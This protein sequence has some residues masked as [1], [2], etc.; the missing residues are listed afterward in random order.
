[1]SRRSILLIYHIAL[2]SALAVL[3]GIALL[4]TA[5]F[6]RIGPGRPSR[7]APGVSVL[8]PARNEEE[9]IERCVASLLAQEYDA[10]EVIV[11]DDQSEDRTGEILGRLK[12][13][14]AGGRLRIIAGEQ[15]PEGWTGKNYACSR[16]AGAATHEV[17][18]F[19]DADTTH[20]PG[21]ISGVVGELRSRNAALLSAVPRQL[22][23]TF[24]ERVIVPIAPFLYFCYLPNRLIPRRNHESLTAANGQVIAVEREAYRRVGGHEAIGDRIVDDLELAR[25]FKREGLKVELLRGDL[26]STCRMYRSLPEI[27]EGFSKNLYPGIG[28]TPLRLLLFV[29]QMVLLFVAPPILLLAALFSGIDGAPPLVVIPAVQTALGMVMRGLSDRAFG[30]NPLHGLLQPLSAASTVGIAI[31]SFLLYRRGSG[32][33]WKGRSLRQSEAR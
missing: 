33:S 26:L 3:A 13:S 15:L 32:G 11:L 6:P 29:L 19:V 22:V 25:L 5:T 30:M 16:L 4:N 27:V 17:M 21:M 8:V 18:I 20:A 28:G 9:T 2:L 24:A 7:D 1:M 12:S 23:P 10:Y 31:R 14:D